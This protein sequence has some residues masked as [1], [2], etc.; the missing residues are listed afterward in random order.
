M[1]EVFQKI[2]IK[3]YSTWRARKLSLNRNCLLLRGL[4]KKKSWERQKK[5]KSELKLFWSP[6]KQERIERRLYHS[7]LKKDCLEVEKTDLRIPSNLH[8]YG[9]HQKPMGQSSS[10][11]IS[12]PRCRRL[13]LRNWDPCRH[14]NYC[15]LQTTKCLAD[16]MRELWNPKRSTQTLSREFPLI[17]VS[18]KKLTLQS[19]KT[20]FVS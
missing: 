1:L 8:P 15:T 11:V 2:E 10:L 12:W 14:I 3:S 5:H 17:K 16:S 20:N 18:Q 19:S 7:L 4:S 6:R 9:L 13:H